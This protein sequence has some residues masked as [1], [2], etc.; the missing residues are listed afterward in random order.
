VGNGDYVFVGPGV[1]E[2]AGPDSGDFDLHFEREDGGDYVYDYFEGYYTY[3]GEGEGEYRLGRTLP[4]PTEHG[5]VAVDGRV[6]LPRDGHVELSGAVSDFDRNAYS[7]RDDGN[8]L[9]NAQVMSAALPRIDLGETGGARLGFSVDARRVAGSFRGVGR[10]REL[11][12]AERWELEGLEL[13]GS[14]ALVEGSSSVELAGGGSAEVS[15]ASLERGDALAA[16]RTEFTVRGKPTEGGRL[17]SSG[18]FVDSRWTGAAEEVRRE[19]RLYR[20]GFEQKLGPVRPGVSYAHDERLQDVDGERFDEYGASLESASVEAVSFG[21]SYAHRATDRT[22]GS[23]WTS[24]STTRT[25]EYRLGTSAWEPLRLQGNVVRRRV[26]F[27]EGFEDPGS[28]YDL[29]SVTLD[30]TSLEGGLTGQVRYSVTATE[31]EEKQRFVTEEDGVE[32]VRIVR[33]GD[34]RP[35][36][37]L[38]ASSR[39]K[40]RPGTRGRG[41]RSMPEPTALGRFLSGLTLT[42]DVKL[43][44]MTTTDDRRRLYLL[45]PGVIM[46]DDTVR[47]ELTGRHIAR[48]LS[49]GSS[50]SVRLAFNTRD[51]LDR[52]YSNES[53]RRKERSGT[54]DVKLTRTGGV[55]YRVQGDAGKREED[56]R[57]GDDYEID[58]RSLLAEADFRGF[59]DLEVKLT[60]SAGMQDERRSGVTATVYKITPA[61]T[62]RLAGRGALSCSVTRIEVE[63]SGGALE[64][65]HYLAEG[66]REGAGAEWR[67]TGDYRFNQFLTGSL[68]YFG[69]ATEGSDPLHTMDFRVNAFF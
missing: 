14:E 67:L 19:R 68:S 58:E 43:R 50:V 12:Y 32:I 6:A 51:A 65:K 40:F 1:F 11:S 49:S 27:E 26:D 10:Y 21:V 29:A 57:T 33:T 16:S 36:T 15:L 66:R 17:W 28:R 7:S 2:Y 53:T 35:V 18:R 62:L 24:A 45:D 39:W 4:A 37:D 47:G 52:S 46:G 5:L 64:G 8:N 13:P 54:A 56:S 42:S 30:H 48:Y 44:E 3:V 38:T 23:G 25:Q 63:A 60:A 59:G 9:G 61:L 31:V 34:Y 55:T 41:G 22:D 20:G 69:E